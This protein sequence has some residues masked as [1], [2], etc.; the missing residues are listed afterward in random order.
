[1]KKTDPLRV[2]ILG[3]GSDAQVA[4]EM[5]ISSGV[6]SNNSELVGFLDGSLSLTGKIKLGEPI[7]GLT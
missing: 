7:L 1:M 4:A 3:V 6:A 5:M 2:V